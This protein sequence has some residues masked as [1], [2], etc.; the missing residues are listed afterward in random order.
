MTDL[1]ETVD[2]MISIDP[3]RRL[4]AEYDQTSIRLARL[5]QRLKCFRDGAGFVKAEDVPL[6]VRQADI[7]EDY[8]EVLQE[9]AQRLGVDL[10]G[11]DNDWK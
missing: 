7:M 1:F 11:G 4:Q 6:M 5:T 2:D 9:R 10:A 8:L 3:A